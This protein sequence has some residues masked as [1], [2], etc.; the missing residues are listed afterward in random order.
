MYSTAN[1]QLRAATWEQDDA[2]IYFSLPVFDLRDLKE[3]FDSYKVWSTV[4]RVKLNG[5]GFIHTSS[6]E[7]EMRLPDY[8]SGELLTLDPIV[9]E[10]DEALV[11]ACGFQTYVDGLPLQNRRINGVVLSCL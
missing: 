5:K 1:G 7:S 3:N 11:F 10:A 2:G 8:I 6:K 9:A 4:N